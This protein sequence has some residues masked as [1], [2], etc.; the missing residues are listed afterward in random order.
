MMIND[1]KIMKNVDKPDV[2]KLKTAQRKKRLLEELEKSHAIITMACK[3]VGLSPETFYQYYRNDSKFAASV[4]QIKENAVDYTESKLFELIEGVKKEEYDPVKKEWI[5]YK[6]PPC[7]TAVTF[8][9][10]TK[11]K[12]K[13]FQE[14]IEQDIHAKVESTSE[15]KI[16]AEIPDNGRG[17]IL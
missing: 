9:L 14:K 4:E 1:N 8:Y 15:V 13:G 17:G 16:V 12:H 2:R 6:Y 5:V 10:K 7:K 11:G 3:N